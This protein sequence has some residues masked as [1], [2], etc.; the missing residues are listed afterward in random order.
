[1]KAYAMFFVL[2]L[3]FLLCPCLKFIIAY[4]TSFKS[5]EFHIQQ[6]ITDWNVKYCGSNLVVV[7]DVGVK[8]EITDYI[9]KKIPKENSVAVNSVN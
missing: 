4:K 8:S 3:Y 1:M 2:L 6:L 5:P 9:L 7:I